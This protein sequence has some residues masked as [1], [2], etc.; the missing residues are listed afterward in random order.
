VNNK[1][2]S[3]KLRSV[4]ALAMACGMLLC[5]CDTAPSETGTIT[6][7]TTETE[8]TVT[9]SD[10]SEF[11]ESS[12]T[13]TTATTTTETT[14]SETEFFDPEEVDLTA[15]TTIDPDRNIGYGSYGFMIGNLEFHSQ[16]DISMLIEP[17]DPTIYDFDARKKVTCSWIDVY[18]VEDSFDMTAYDPT[19]RFLSFYND[20][21]S[22]SFNAYKELGS[23]TT[24]KGSE[25]TL[26]LTDITIISDNLEIHILPKN[27]NAPDKYNISICG[28]GYYVSED[29]LQMADFVL[30]SLMEEPGV[31]PLEG[32]VS[33]KDHTYYF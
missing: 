25:L 12:E 3:G 30:S 7:D 15:E 18:Y 29:Q 28:R 21:T 14:P 16:N 19:Y 2:N 13:T 20:D 1:S 11:T 8:T 24:P 5:A 22:I 33:G 10:S 26:Y 9:T 17:E 4:A 27:S 23:W 6:S 32:I 31:D